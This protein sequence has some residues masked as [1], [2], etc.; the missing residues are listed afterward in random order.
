MLHDISKD[1]GLDM[2]SGVGFVGGLGGNFFGCFGMIPVEMRV[3][4]WEKYEP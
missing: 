2:C 3:G 1:I 4:G